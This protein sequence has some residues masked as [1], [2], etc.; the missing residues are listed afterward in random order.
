MSAF[1]TT[2]GNKGLQQAEGLIFETGHATGT[3]V[4]LP[5]PKGGGHQHHG[6]HGHGQTSPSKAG[7]HA[8]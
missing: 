1:E 3:G 6:H 7:G 8:H 2:S 5:A 4:D